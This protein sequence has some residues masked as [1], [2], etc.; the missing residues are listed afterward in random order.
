MQPPRETG[1]AKKVKLEDITEKMSG[2]CPLDRYRL[3]IIPSDCPKHGTARTNNGRAEQLAKS[4]HN[5]TE[6]HMKRW[7]VI[8]EVLIAI[9]V[10]YAGISHID[11]VLEKECFT[12]S[13]CMEMFGGDGY[14][15][16]A[17][18]LDIAEG[19]QKWVVSQFE[20]ITR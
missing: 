15:E 1:T 8:L 12:D 11:H 10:I 9:G 4:A 17:Y 20:N 6:A 19:A 16:E 14:D 18:K 5:S 2:I 3:K 13:E 7:H